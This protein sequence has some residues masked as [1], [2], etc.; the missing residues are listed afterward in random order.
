MW[1]RESRSMEGSSTSG[2]NI[3]PWWGDL[4][5]QLWLQWKQILADDFTLCQQEEFQQRALLLRTDLAAP[6]LPVGNCCCSTEF[7]LLQKSSMQGKDTQWRS[8][9]HLC[10]Q[11]EG[12]SSAHFSYFHTAAVRGLNISS[13]FK[14]Q[15][16]FPM[17]AVTDHQPP[18]VVLQLWLDQIRE[19]WSQTLFLL[20]GLK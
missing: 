14:L 9:S 6:C 4:R 5:F 20:T 13:T 7:N 12:S 11:L 18:P 8:S 3:S 17:S 19:L 2:F 16:P 10:E 15:L 1:K